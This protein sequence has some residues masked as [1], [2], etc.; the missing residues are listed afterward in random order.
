MAGAY[1]PLD[2][3]HAPLVSPLEDLNPATAHLKPEWA[4]SFQR[5]QEC[6]LSSLFDE[7][8]DYSVSPSSASNANRYHR[9]ELLVFNVYKTL[10]HSTAYGLGPNPCSP[11]YIFYSGRHP[12]DRMIQRGTPDS[13]PGAAKF[14]GLGKKIWEN[15]KGLGGQASNSRDLPTKNS[16]VPDYPTDCM[17][18]EYKNPPAR[19]NLIQSFLDRKDFSTRQS[20]TVACVRFHE[21]FIEWRLIPP[22]TERHSKNRAGVFSGGGSKGREEDKEKQIHLAPIAYPL[23]RSISLD[24]SDG[25]QNGFKKTTSISSLKHRAR[26][27]S[28]QTAPAS[29]GAEPVTPPKKEVRRV[30]T[31]T[32]RDIPAAKIYLNPTPH[33]ITPSSGPD[34]S[35]AE[36]FMGKECGEES[37]NPIYTTLEELGSVESQPI[38]VF[39]S[40]TGPGTKTYWWVSEDSSWRIVY[41]KTQDIN[42]SSKRHSPNPPTSV[43]AATTPSSEQEGKASL[44]NSSHNLIFGKPKA[45]EKV[46]KMFPEV[47]GGCVRLYIANSD[48]PIAQVHLLTGQMW[49]LKH[50]TLETIDIAITVI[51]S[52]VNLERHIE[53]EHEGHKKRPSRFHGSSAS[54]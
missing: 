12:A 4:S 30:P 35:L 9:D 51:F 15:I 46:T 38:S 22:V 2:R 24:D 11:F 49:I 32:P 27:G 20:S 18:H 8:R 17:S 37:S 42:V 50:L 28:Q 45:E 52:V 6:F 31:N 53:D 34:R 48:E 47:K 44:D 3:V 10:H 23:P 33:L 40:D 19:P 25:F 36:Y 29:P 14:N 54:Y 16:K 39:F 5:L 26:L 1:R 13:S 21:E 41:D 43:A 7:G